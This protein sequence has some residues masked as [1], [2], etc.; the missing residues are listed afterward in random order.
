VNGPVNRPG[1]TDSSP[2]EPRAGAVDWA[3]VLLLSALSGFM[4]VVGVLFL[5]LYVGPVPMPLV[6]V[7]VGLALAVLPRMSYRLTRRIGAA[8][9]PPLVWLAVTIW[10]NLADNALYRGFPV[11]WQGW[12][13]LLLLGV[14]SLASAGSVGL[15]WGD[16]LRARLGAP[17]PVTRGPGD[18]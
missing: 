15:L 2:R 1:G 11:V 5:P 10:L 8:A 7:P 16:H 17:T 3:L 13:F 18:R 14:G 6:V 9:A 4:A 12:Q